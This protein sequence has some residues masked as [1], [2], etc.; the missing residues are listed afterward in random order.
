MIDSTSEDEEGLAILEDEF[1]DAMRDSE[2]ASEE[3]EEELDDMAQLDVDENLAHCYVEY[4]SGLN[5]GI[6]K[7]FLED[8]GVERS[9]EECIEK[10]NDYVVQVMDSP[11]NSVTYQVLTEVADKGIIWKTTTRSILESMT[12]GFVITE[13]TVDKKG[14]SKKKEVKV[15]SKYVKSLNRNWVKY[16]T[17]DPSKAGGIDG[18]QMLNTFTGFPYH[19]KYRPLGPLNIHHTQVRVIINTIVHHLREVLC[20]GNKKI[21][22]VVKKW[23]RM[24]R[25]HPEWRPELVLV[26]IGEEGSGKSMFFRFF[27]KLFGKNAVYLAEPKSLLA[28]FAGDQ[29]DDRVLVCCD[30]ANFN[31]KEFGY[32]LKNLVTAEERHFEKKGINAKQIK[33]YLNGVFTTNSKNCLP[34]DCTGKNRRYFPVTVSDE[35]RGDK[36]Y[37]DELERLIDNPIGLAVFDFWLRC[38]K[39]PAQRMT[40]PVT[41]ELNNMMISNMSDVQNWWLQVL[42]KGRHISYMSVPNCELDNEWVLF[43]VD[44]G[45][46]HAMFL[47][48]NKSSRVRRTDFSLKLKQILPLN[49]VVEQK[50]LTNCRLPG[51]EECRKFAHKKLGIKIDDDNFIGN[52]EKNTRKRKKWAIFNVAAKRASRSPSP[53]SVHQVA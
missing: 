38:K 33:N 21:Y 17:Y 32:R 6:L 14:N 39:V 22:N 3:E 13:E 20:R 36:D 35:H 28:K 9:L 23:M 43:P 25:Q 2:N 41:E 50:D 12:D 51:L 4:A 10:L 30:E 47:A 24:V 27:A 16:M 5:L 29:L 42:D 8:S 18:H 7:Q 46:L 15:F 11:G 31:D 49:S 26:F 53:Q 19:C 45:E 48:A 40:V 1:R 34:V 37:F 52:S 44:I